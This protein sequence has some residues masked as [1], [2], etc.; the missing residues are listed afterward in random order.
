MVF[1]QTLTTPT[2][3]TGSP[4]RPKL[5]IVLYPL[6]LDPLLQARYARHLDS[7]I[8]AFVENGGRAIIRACDGDRRGNPVILPRPAFAEAMRRQYSK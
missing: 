8:E 4:H 3:P 6:F 1:R 5:R 7:L 2:S